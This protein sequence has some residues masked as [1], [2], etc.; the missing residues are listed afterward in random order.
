MSNVHVAG[1]VHR[2]QNAARLDHGHS[3]QGYLDVFYIIS[4]QWRYP[5]L[6]VAPAQAKLALKHP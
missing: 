5:T 1:I 4:P 2:P 6:P 3:H